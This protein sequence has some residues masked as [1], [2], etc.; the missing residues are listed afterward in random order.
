LRKKDEEASEKDCPYCLD[1]RAEGRHPVSGRARASWALSRT[2]GRAITPPRPVT[3]LA[4]ALP[5]G[6]GRYRPGYNPS[7]DSRL[8][9]AWP[10]AGLQ[11][12]WRR[13]LGL[14]V[15]PLVPPR[16][17]EDRRLGR[18]VASTA[19]AFILHRRGR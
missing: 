2:D 17:P 12:A 16:N 5:A 7:Q 15:E 18:L 11:G 13:L 14:T 4:A 1:Q 6:F 3:G 8:E 9:G 10:G 19:I